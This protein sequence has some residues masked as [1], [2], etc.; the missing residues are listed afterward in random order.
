MSYDPKTGLVYIPV[1]DAPLVFAELKNTPAPEKFIDDAFGT[2]LA[3]PT[4]SFDAKALET[5]YGKMPKFDP[6]DPK[7]GRSIIRSMLKAWN[8]VT[9]K[10]VWVQP[11]SEGYLSM[12]GGTMS[13]AGNLVFKGTNSGELRAY[14]ADTGKLLNA[15]QTGTSIMAAPSTYTVDGVQYVAVMAG[16][17]GDAIGSTL[18]PKSAAAHYDNEGRVLVFRLGGAH[19][20]PR[21][22]ER[23]I[24][25]LPAPP[26]K[27]GTAAD[28]AAGGV[29][30]RTWCRRCHSGHGAT[31]LPDLNRM[32]DGMER[33][34]TFKQIVLE[35][36]LAA[37]GMERF[38]DVIKPHDAELIHA[39]LIDRAQAAYEAENANK[40]P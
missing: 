33:L 4:P 37:G 28:V 32:G 12:E 17:G 27:E 13:T 38:D 31:I 14:A 15:I 8:P 5:A 11:L 3:F 9:Q 21:T 7:T 19:D 16:L 23:V 34:D 1:F 2:F 18:P 39:Y 30:F 24:E 22:A 36:V 20:V 29:L 25:P 6:V 26:P 10:E 40:K 35:G